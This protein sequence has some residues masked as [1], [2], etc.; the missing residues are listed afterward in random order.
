MHTQAE[1]IRG[2]VTVVAL[3]VKSGVT[4]T[5]NIITTNFVNE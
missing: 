2:E 1:Q 4:I 5:A 3:I